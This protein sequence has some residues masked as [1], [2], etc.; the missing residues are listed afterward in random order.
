[1]PPATRRYHHRA[2]PRRARF[3]TT[4][5]YCCYV[6]AHLLDR[7]SNNII[8]SDVFLLRRVF[9]EKKKNVHRPRG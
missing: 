7:E 8:G 4:T 9:S 1:M 2:N 5:V 6:F 3:P